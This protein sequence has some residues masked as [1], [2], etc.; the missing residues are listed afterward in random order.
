[1]VQSGH[2]PWAGLMVSYTGFPIVGDD[3][4]QDEHWAKDDH[5]Y[6]E[7]KLNSFKQPVPQQASDN[8]KSHGKV[9]II[10]KTY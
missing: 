7:V 3:V 8:D 1:M 6:A 9:F 5:K 4:E 10:I 2:D